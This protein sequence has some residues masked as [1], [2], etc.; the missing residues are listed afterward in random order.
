L[1][2]S[3]FWEDADLNP[4]RSRFLKEGQDKTG[5]VVYW[6]SR[7]QRA[8]DNWALIFAQEL[9]L[10]R[11]SP[12]GVVFSL[13][14]EFLGAAMRQY[15]FMLR[16]LREVEEALAKKNIPFALLRR[17]PGEAVSN[18]AEEHDVG[19]LVTD[20]SPLATKRLWNERVV[21]R[22]TVPVYEVD[23]HNVVPCW[24]ASPKQ[25]YAARTFRPKIKRLIPEFCEE[26]PALKA[27]PHLWDLGDG[28]D[29]DRARRD[30]SVDRSVPEVDWIV[31]GPRAAKE[32][33]CRFLKEK[34]SAYDRERNDPAVD[35]QSNLSPYLHFGMISAQ[36]VALEVARSGADPKSKA[37]FLEE[38][39]VRGE[40]S[41]NFCFYNPGYDSF[42][43]FPNWAKKTL[44][45]HR[46]DPREYFYDQKELE[47][48]TTHDDLWNAAQKEMVIRGK[49]HGY[50]RMYWAKKILEWTESPEE[51][52]RI[53][54]RLNDRYELDGRDPNGYVGVAWSI[55]G[56][57][58]RAWGER[59]VF[60]KVRY[61]S[62]RGAGSKF[63]VKA[64]V[65]RVASLD[66][67]G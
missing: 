7:D 30:L 61:M 18:F 43:A 63:D 40:L 38:L 8:E 25:E 31:P 10:K 5:P 21:Q 66:N 39:V 37:A 36:K 59:E 67:V 60:G 29:W 34:L 17:D 9:A 45:D 57:H 48:A 3:S 23:A 41:D 14:D 35:G 13:A 50:L 11:R 47:R 26:F 55:G 58:D 49:M 19:V 12:L 53:A 27:H 6:M 64:Y 56:V 32:A 46:S 28:A 16:G 65:E 24:R 51:A 33:M 4:D 62:R 15:G 44:N 20:F 54:I 42:E 22:L 1:G 2:C 52:Q